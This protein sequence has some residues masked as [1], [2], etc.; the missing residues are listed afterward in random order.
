MFFAKCRRR[1]SQ[2]A[3]WPGIARAIDDMIQ[4]CPTCSKFCE[5]PAE[6][7][8]PTPFLDYPMKKV[9]ADLFEWRKG[10]YLYSRYI[11][12]IKCISTMHFSCYHS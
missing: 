4:K 9:A 5:Q 11:E 7:L 8:H 12:V 6:P 1:A 3:W 10:L 2:L